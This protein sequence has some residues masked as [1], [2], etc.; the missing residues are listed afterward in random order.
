VETQSGCAVSGAVSF[1]VQAIPEA[2]FDLQLPVDAPPL[3]GTPLNLSQDGINYEWLIN[4]EVVSTE[5]EPSLTFES[6]GDYEVVLVATND[7]N[8]NDSAAALY[9]VIVP[10]YDLELIE[11]AYQRQ[12]NLLVLNA[13]VGNN[14]NVAVNVFDAAIEVGRDV[15]FTLTTETAIP[16]GQIADVPIG[17]EIGYIPGRD[18]P[19]TC[20][21]IANPNGEAD[22]DTTNNY[23]CIGL[24]NQRATFAAPY[25]NP[26]T[27]EVKL[28]F[29]L[30]ADGP[31]NVEIT[32][33]D[34]RIMESFDLE[35]KE[36]LNTL[37]YPLTGWSEGMYFVKFSYKNQEEVFRLVVAR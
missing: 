7:L 14:G 2:D 30:P 27:D 34:G 19:Y 16:A 29:V 36:G 10:E 13:I 37:D 8:C 3:S 11:L 12:G 18:L 5:F 21:R 35:L 32:G 22:T 15:A 20:V 24:N 31:L 25:P 1:L 28:T 4:G 23:L 26:A 6:A 9:T 17:S 33:A